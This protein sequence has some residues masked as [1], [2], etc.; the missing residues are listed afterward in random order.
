MKKVIL[1]KKTG[2][3]N[4]DGTTVQ[5]LDFR[6]ILFYCNIDLNNKN[7]FNLPEGVYYFPENFKYKLINPIKHKLKK[8]PVKERNYTIDNFKFLFKPNPSKAT[9]FYNKPITDTAIIVFDTSY[10]LKPLPELFYTFYHELGHKFY[11]TEKKADLY[12]MNLMLKKGYNKSQIGKSIIHSL[13]EKQ[14]E[15]KQN[16][17]N[18]LL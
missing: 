9:I 10:K 3:K 5:I 15:R 18:N 8:L 6:G 4:L 14:Y 16:I 13:S 11:S 2:V 17:V 7:C 1:H 12:A